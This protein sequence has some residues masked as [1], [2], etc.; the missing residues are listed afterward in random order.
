MDEHTHMTTS[1]DATLSNASS[2]DTH[3]SKSKWNLHDTQWTLSLFGTAVGA[4]ILFLPINI[5]IGGFWPLIILAC[6]AFPMTFLAHRGLAR[7]VL[8]S[9]NK[10]ADLENFFGKRVHPLH[11]LSF[12][13]RKYIAPRRTLGTEGTR[14]VPYSPF[15]ISSSANTTQQVA[16]EE[17]FS[18][19][20]S[21]LLS[22]M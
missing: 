13:H 20:F 19:R 11:Q 9:K 21:A 16:P 22:T 10:E 18:V 2:Q 12:L 7:F 17:D 3:T 6:L 4:G 5:G 15:Y 1:Q 8:S 14:A